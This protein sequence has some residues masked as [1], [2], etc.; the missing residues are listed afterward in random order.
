MDPDT[1]WL[2]EQAERI[3]DAGLR[4]SEEFEARLRRLAAP[5]EIIH[6]TKDDALIVPQEQI[7]SV[8]KE[9][10]LELIDVLAGEAGATCGRLEKEINTL[11][12]RILKL[13][14]TNEVLRSFITTKVAT[15]TSIKGKSDAA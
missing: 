15:L 14:I 10:V 2:V 13:E 5:P 6:K 9:D 12:E 8:S 1:R 3:D 4:R 11:R 7:N